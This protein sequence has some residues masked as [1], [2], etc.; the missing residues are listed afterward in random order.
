MRDKIAEW[1]EAIDETALFAD[2]FDGA[3][4]GLTEDALNNAFRVCYSVDD[5]C[6]ILMVDHD[7]GYDEAMEYFDFNVRGAIVG[8]STPIFVI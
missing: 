3:I 5:C 4:I 7:M 1:L 2:G 6:E 8:P